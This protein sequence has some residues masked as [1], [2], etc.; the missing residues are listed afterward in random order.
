MNVIST[1]GRTPLGIAATLGDVRIIQLLLGTGN[2]SDKSSTSGNKNGQEEPIDDNQTNLGYFI[3]VHDDVTSVDAITQCEVMD[4]NL[5]EAETPEGMEGLEWDVEMTEGENEDE[6]DV[7]SNQYRWY[8]NI[9]S[10]THCIVV[11]VPNC[12]DVN[13]QDMSGRCAIHY[14]ADQGHYDA[15]KC[16]INSGRSIT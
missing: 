15:V 6:E 7:W 13:Q 9:L 11:D 4:M 1:S 14:A 10:K 5:N 12:C 16:L 3:M 8:A 2:E